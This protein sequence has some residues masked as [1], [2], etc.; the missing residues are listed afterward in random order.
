MKFHLRVMLKAPTCQYFMNT[1]EI[2][3]ISVSGVCV[4]VM[5]IC[6]CDDSLQGIIA[7]P[8]A[9]TVEAKLNLFDILLSD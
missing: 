7:Q 2:Y 4:H 5:N 9:D 6:G 3:K 1:L 8:T